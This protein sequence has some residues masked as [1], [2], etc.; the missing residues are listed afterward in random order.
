MEKQ[1][2]VLSRRIKLT[3]VS[4]VLVSVLA[5]TIVALQ[6]SP[7]ET[8]PTQ[9][10]TST[11]QDGQKSQNHFSVIYRGF[12]PDYNASYPDYYVC[13]NDLAGEKMQLY[14]WLEIKNQ[15]ADPYYF[16]ID[17][18]G[19]PPEWETYQEIGRIPVDGTRNVYTSLN[20]TRP[21]SIPEG[22]FTESIE[23]E[24]RAYFDQNYTEFYSSD[25]F[26]VTFHFID[27]K[28]PTWNIL[29]YDNFDNGTDQGWWNGEASTK[30]YR[31]WRYS[32]ETMA[33]GPGWNLFPNKR[34][35]IPNIY[36]EAYLIFSWRGSY[37]YPSNRLV[38]IY[39]NGTI[40]FEPDFSPIGRGTLPQWYQST[41]P[42]WVGC[43]HVRIWFNGAAS[44]MDD[45]YVIAR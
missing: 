31:S 24:V 2:I 11:Q 32:L 42:L 26:T 17:S 28:S 25:S 14:V 18:V 41:L 4:V 13:I 39:L 3:L 16:I 22:L 15:E 43:T 45:V 12:V 29:Y 6:L 38:A 37:Y 30:Y 9:E 23:I 27:R 10:G 7:T 35:Y 5:G 1:K 33:S 19:A 20:R 36:D 40:Y 34:F 8:P 21:T 44:Y